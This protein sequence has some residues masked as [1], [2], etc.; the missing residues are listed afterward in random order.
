MIPDLSLIE[1]MLIFKYKCIE[2]TVFK[3]I[4]HLKKKATFGFDLHSQS[5]AQFTVCYL[6]QLIQS[7]HNLI[8][9]TCKMEI[10]IQPELQ[11]YYEDLLR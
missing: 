8:F 6:E 4:P 10:T 11:D 1:K 2:M 3:E 9:V 5:S 7:S